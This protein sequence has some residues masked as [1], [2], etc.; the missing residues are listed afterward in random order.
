[1]Q[2]RHATVGAVT[3]SRRS[4]RHRCPHRHAGARLQGGDGAIP[5]PWRDR[6]RVGRRR[7]RDGPAGVGRRQARPP[8]R[9][10]SRKPIR[11]RSS[12][13]A[14][15]KARRRGG[16]GSPRVRI[17]RRL[18]GAGRT[19]AVRASVDSAECRGCCAWGAPLRAD[20]LAILR[21]RVSSSWRRDRVRTFAV[22]GA[23]GSARIR[24]GVEGR[25]EVASSTCGEV[26]TDVHVDHMRRYAGPDGA[27][28]IQSADTAHPTTVSGR[29]SR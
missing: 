11:S 27:A 2:G 19:G 10:P 26:S 14:R 6:T 9:T 13:T 4:Q 16:V 1:M 28:V 20:R 12:W 24:L 21:C 3:S 17:G 8:R 25:R 23:S 7:P 5:G 29:C 22:R 18:V 15:Q